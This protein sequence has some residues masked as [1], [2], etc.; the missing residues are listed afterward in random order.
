MT[1][2]IFANGVSKIVPIIGG[3]ATGGLTYATFKPGAKKLQKSFQ[4]LNLCNPEYYKNPENFPEEDIEYSEFGDADMN[5][6]FDYDSVIN[7]PE[8]SIFDAGDNE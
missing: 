8:E 5:S 4:S 7:V 6:S 1:K 3:I 2:Q